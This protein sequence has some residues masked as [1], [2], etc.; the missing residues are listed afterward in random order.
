M[1]KNDIIAV[2]LIVFFLPFFVREL[3]DNELRNVSIDNF[4]EIRQLKILWVFNFY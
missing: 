2:L 3:F 4:N 1:H